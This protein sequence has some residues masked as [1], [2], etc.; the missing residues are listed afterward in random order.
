M[1]T[2]TEVGGDYYDFY[3]APDGTSTIAIGDATGHGLNAGTMVTAIK[4]L[5]SLLAGKCKLSRMLQL[6]SEAVRGMKL[7][8]LY[9]ALALI[10][11]RGNTLQLAGV[12]MPPAII[13]RADTQ[14]VEIVELKGMPLGSFAN[15]PYSEST[16]ILKKDDIVLLYTDGLPELFN[17]HGEMLGYE[18]IPQILAESGDQSLDEITDYIRNIAN[19][20]LAGGE[21]KDDITFLVLKSTVNQEELVEC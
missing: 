16:I 8:R 4:G 18:K 11:L 21:L 9:M 14:K 1:K 7:P 17:P 13:Y 19:Q 5:F 12:G 6:F 3:V 2:A 15:Y 20:W 10:R